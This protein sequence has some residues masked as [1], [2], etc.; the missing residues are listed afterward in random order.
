MTDYSFMKTGNQQ[1][2]QQV[3]ILDILTVLTVFTEDAMK[4]A[5]IFTKHS[6]RKLITKEDT[7]NALKIRTFYGKEFWS[8]PNIKQRLEEC[9]NFLEQESDDEMMSEDETIPENEQQPEITCSCNICTIDI[10]TLWN[11]WTPTEHLDIILKD[12]IDLMNN[13]L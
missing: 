13:D 11:N 7:I 9:R 8:M 1:N 4:I 3:E 12:K 2:E 5:A 6:N 10:Q